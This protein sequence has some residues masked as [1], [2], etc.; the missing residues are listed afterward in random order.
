[1]AKTVFITGSSRGIGAAIA[2]I[3]HA[4]GYNVAINY[5]K[6][7]EVSLLALLDNNATVDLSYDTL[8]NF[9]KKQLEL[10]NR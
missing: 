4:N 6:S 10:G 2:K 3:F 1:M 8:E 9:C 7:E 5:N